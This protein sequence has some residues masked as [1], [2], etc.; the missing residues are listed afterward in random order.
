MIASRIPSVRSSRSIRSNA[1]AHDPLE[2]IPCRFQGS[3]LGRTVSIGKEAITI[4]AIINGNG[5]GS[6]GLA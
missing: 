3:L 6:Q 2:N 5:D 1:V 4:Q